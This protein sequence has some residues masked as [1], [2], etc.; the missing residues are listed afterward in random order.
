MISLSEKRRS[1]MVLRMRRL[2][3]MMEFSTSSRPFPAQSASY[4]SIDAR[5]PVDSW[6]RFFGSTS[7]HPISFARVKIEY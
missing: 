7:T 5:I 4:W 1:A 2:M 6:P 3:D